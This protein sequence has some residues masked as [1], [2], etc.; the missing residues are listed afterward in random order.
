MTRKLIS[1][2]LILVLCLSMAI[3]VNADDKAIDFVVDEWDIFTADELSVLNQTAAGVYERTG[4]G[5][6]FVFTQ[7]EALEE[8]DVDGLT[9]GITDY[10]IMLENDANWFTFYG[11]KGLEIDLETEEELRAIYDET[12]TYADGVAAFLFATE[13]CFPAV[14]DT[15]EP[16]AGEW[17]VFDDADLLTDA[18]EETLS[19]KLRDVSHT[20]Q[21]EIVVCTVAAIGDSDVDAFLEYLY[22]YMGF[23][24]GE[25]HDGVMLLLCMDTRDYRILSNGFAGVAID[26]GA[27][28]SIGDE[29]VPYLSDGQY[30]EGFGAFADQCVYYLDGYINGFPFNTGMNA[31]I[32]LAVGLLV[33]AIV[34]GVLKGQLKS[35]RKQDQANNYVKPGSL[36]LTLSNDIFLYRNVTQTEKES[37]SSSSGSSGS[38]RS[39]GGG[40]F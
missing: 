27:I 3:S 35:V 20:Y 13:E 24:Y 9:N 6:F 28:D 39:T 31:L 21:A 12:E 4:V 32:S 10:V 2:V 19:Q 25:N 26:T 7:D 34:S 40:S 30:A 17:F 36:Q 14:E 38:S 5:V 18:E 33:G 15:T 29:I 1:V 22:D 11:G 16:E 23:G 37:K 8:Y